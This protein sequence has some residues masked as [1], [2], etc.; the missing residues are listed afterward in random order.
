[1]ALADEASQQTSPTVEDT[2]MGTWPQAQ[3]PKN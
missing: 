1:M 3:K 2:M